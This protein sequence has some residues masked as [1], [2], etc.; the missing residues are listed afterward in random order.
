MS[1]IKLKHVSK[2]GKQLIKRHGDSWQVIR[3]QTYVQFSA[4]RGEWVLIQPTSSTDT[5]HSRWI[6]TTNDI[7]FSIGE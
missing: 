1:Q 3:S 6:H 5:K 7:N 2:K 4:M